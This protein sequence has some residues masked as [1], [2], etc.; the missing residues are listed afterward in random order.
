MAVMKRVCLGGTFDVLHAGH[1]LLLEA[2]L[3]AGERLVIGLATDEFAA[4]RRSPGRKL[5]PYGSA[6]RRCASG[7]RRTAH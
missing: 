2:A 7:S 3:G 6:R 1:A 5:A 4:S